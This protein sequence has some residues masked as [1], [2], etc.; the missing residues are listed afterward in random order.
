MV[1]VRKRNRSRH[2]SIVLRGTI[3]EGREL[4]LQDTPGVLKVWSDASIEPLEATKA[5]DLTF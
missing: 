1:K 3:E 5:I 4:N 2:D